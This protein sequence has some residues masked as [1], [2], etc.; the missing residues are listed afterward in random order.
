[1]VNLDSIDSK[2]IENYYK[3]IG[4]NV[5]RIRKAK[6]VSQLDLSLRIG[7]KSVSII[8][9]AEINHNNH[10]FNIEHL[11]KIAYVLEVNICEFFKVD[12]DK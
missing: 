7:H 1:M 8:S 2:Y 6:K 4:E 12:E 9:C 10:H 3:L 5:K 11:L